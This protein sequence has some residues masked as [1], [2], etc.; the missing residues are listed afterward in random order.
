M[1][2]DNL[3]QQ[4][5][6]IVFLLIREYTVP[7]VASIQKLKLSQTKHRISK[8]YKKIAVKSRIGLIKKHYEEEIDDLLNSLTKKDDKQQKQQVA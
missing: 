1:K 5:K 6:E 3:E 2:I 4:E 7:E 8:I